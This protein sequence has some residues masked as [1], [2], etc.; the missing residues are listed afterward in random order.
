MQP[1]ASSGFRCRYGGKG[2]SFHNNIVLGSVS[3]A[4]YIGAATCVLSANNNLYLD[5]SR[6][7]RFQFNGTFHDLSSWRG[8]GYDANSRVL[9]PQLVSLAEPELGV[10]TQSPAIDGG[11]SDLAGERDFL[12]QPRVVGAAVDI[13][14][15]ERQ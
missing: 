10:A 6:P 11:D 5:P 7:T 15:V 14:A 4:I 9:D 1:G 3:E 8:L 12:G 13:G 2:A